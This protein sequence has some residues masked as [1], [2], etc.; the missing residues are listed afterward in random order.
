MNCNTM[1]CNPLGWRKDYD[2]YLV[3]DHQSHKRSEF[4]CLDSAPETRRGG[5][6][7]RNGAMFYPV[8]AVRGALP[9]PT[10]VLMA[11]W[12]GNSLVSSARNN[13]SDL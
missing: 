5:E 11:T 10:D 3:S 12:A 2:G 6:D 13:D 7:D 9:R 1:V 8:Q 4:I